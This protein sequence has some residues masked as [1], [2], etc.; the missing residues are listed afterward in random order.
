M[1][2]QS[3]T[4]LT[5]RGALAGPLR[6]QVFRGKLGA[7]EVATVKDGAVSPPL[8]INDIFGQDQDAAT[9]AALL[10]QN[11]LPADRFEIS[12]TPVVVN[13]GA[14]LIMFDAGNGAATGRRPNAGLA[15]ERLALLGVSPEQIDIVVLTHFHPDHIGG[16]IEDGAPAYPNARY[17]A[18]AAEFDFWTAEG[19]MSG[20]TERVAKLTA[21][22]VAPLAEN[23]TMIAGDQDVV[24]G[25]TAVSAA[26][27]TPGHMAYHIE[28]DGARLMI[29]A[30]AANHAVLSLQKPDWHV[31]F[32]MDKEAAAATRKQLFGMIAADKIPF[33]GYHMPFPAIGYL[34]PLGDGFRYV[35]QS[36][37]LAL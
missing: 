22:N 3:P 1:S 8:A 16:L 27:H 21:A 30:D 35:A 37:Q 36:G 25:V 24:S 28:S 17:V 15:R 23:M 18:P 31:R 5:R 6:P 14:A 34:E 32:D 2:T 26:G 11:F 13:T 4:R 7:F 9:V 10:K 33:A 20:P 19:R 29:C 12:F